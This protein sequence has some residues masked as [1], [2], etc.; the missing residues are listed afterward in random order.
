MKQAFVLCLV[1]A[2]SAACSA[3]DA[4][5][6]VLR[7]GMIGLDTSHVLAFTKLINDPKAT[8]ELAD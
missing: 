8:G 2:V 1:W 5:A 7:V 4:P 3:A 6:K